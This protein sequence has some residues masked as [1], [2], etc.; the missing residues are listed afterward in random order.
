MSAVTLA[1][2]RLWLQDRLAPGDPSYNMF[3]V[4]RLR[5]DLD[6]T[7]FQRA[8]EDV[9]ARHDV[10][11][12]T[13]VA[14]ADGVPC[15]RV[16]PAAPV[17]IELVDVPEASARTEVGARTNAPFDLA[18]GPLLR[19]SLLRLSSDDHVLVIV[20]HHIIADGWSLDVL[21]T[22]L[23]HRYRG[24]PLPP[25]PST[26]A[27]YAQ[28]RRAEGVPETARTYW[29]EQLA[30]LPDLELPGD[31]APQ[32]T[33]TAGAY[34]T[35]RLP[36]ALAEAVEQLSRR[37]RCSLFMVLLAAYQTLL[38][39]YTG[40]I[41]VPVGT[42]T[43]GRDRVETEP[44]IGYLIDTLI[45]RGDLRGDPTF[46]ELLV[47]TRKTALSAY[48]RPD[49]PFEELLAGRA[50]GEAG[51]ALLRTTFILQN[52]DTAGFAL[53]GL[54]TE[55]FDD[56]FR[57]SKLDL[58][59]EAWREPDGLTL[60]FGYRTDRFSPAA[61][62]RLGE[63]FER[64]LRQVV[65]DPAVPLSRLSL[66]GPDDLEHLE[67]WGT[68]PAAEPAGGTVL[69]LIRDRIDR[70][71]DA[72][73]LRQGERRVTYGELGD[74]IAETAT[75]L[76]APGSVTPLRRPSSIDL[77]VEMLAC[78]AAGSAYLTIDPD[79]PPARIDFLLR[80]GGS[81]PA[82]DTAYVIYTSGT[83]GRPKGVRVS[84]RALAV[85][86][87]WMVEH[88]GLGPGDTVLQF[89]SPSFDTHAEE[90]FPCLAAGATL[91]LREEPGALLPEILATPAG[92]D[93]TVL[94]LPTAYWHELVSTVDSIAW[95][96]RLRL[97]ILG[98]DQVDA[99]AVRRWGG[100][101]RLVNTYGPT[102]TT[103]VATAHD[104][105]PADA[106]GVVP[107]GRPL[108]GVRAYVLDGHLGRLPAG[109]P[110]E[111]YLGGAGV[112]DGYHRRPGLTADRFLPDPYGAP[113]TRMY[114]TGDRARF[115]ADGT[116]TFL[117]RTD[118]QVKI[119]G[120]RIETG[121]VQAQLLTHPQV[122][123]AAVVAREVTAGDRQLVAYVTG[124]A[125][126]ASLRAHLAASL[127]AH[128][129]PT[130]FVRLERLPLTTHGKVD[131]QAL[132]HPLR[133]PLRAPVSTPPRTAAEE[134][135]AQAWRDV[136]GVPAV[137]V[138]DD[139]FAVGGHSL[140]AARVAARLTA[141]VEVD[142]PLRTFFTHR[143]LA[144]LA[145]AVE[146]LI[147]ADLDR[148]TDD[149]ALALLEGSA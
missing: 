140:L 10:L 59:V 74:L 94:D 69:D 20:M 95:P 87:R 129:V 90:V 91:L 11:R 113:G 115:N 72:V 142:V 60:H 93:I 46:S 123:Q 17:P 43:A 19:V 18:A 138:H 6:H 16:A 92:R 136:L 71:P 86:V 119:R 49:I 112:A 137:G 68:G 135:V 54:V 28:R 3:I 30:D 107:I 102:E 76:T 133:Q 106:D 38:H 37:A 34:H 89:A 100:R 4:R 84:H 50:R 14:D 108:A 52:P 125:D 124:A 78:W 77:I 149:E 132:P 7:A 146:E 29:L 131:R 25:L 47:R 83:T 99:A 9:A 13:F 63:H 39:K 130:R 26:F 85:R 81:G 67:S 96:A 120:F 117:G 80:D 33:S 118:D 98:G 143:T 36:D 42:F 51:S 22:E 147:V 12:S 101:A 141:T 15:R 114:R 110:G 1:Q 122:E 48:E 134:L 27:R 53:D 32:H 64:L 145:V 58:A 144:E 103:I 5:G 126:A 31:L 127:P 79:Y 35:H 65:A 56:G 148:L 105:G 44:L 61:A 57:H 121:E 104:L 82:G 88:Y 73:A 55:G 116:L 21:A 40:S 139:F 41:D 66:L 75:R 45:L 24:R 62:A 109:I 23:A 2:E 8:V 70:S 111:L 97:L 128:M